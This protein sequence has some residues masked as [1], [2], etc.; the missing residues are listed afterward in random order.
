[1]L[2]KP[3]TAT[4]AG[5]FERFTAVLDEITD[6]V[7]IIVATWNWTRYRRYG[8]EA[9]RLYD[10]NDGEPGGSVSIAS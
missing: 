7:P 5:R 4:G 1:M 2:D 3:L 6:N 10:L 8:L 9:T